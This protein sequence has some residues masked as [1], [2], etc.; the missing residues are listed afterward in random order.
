LDD[1]RRRRASPPIEE[2]NG[3]ERAKFVLSFQIRSA[4]QPFY[5]LSFSL[6]F[7]LWQ[8]R[9]RLH[10]SA[11][12]AGV[13]EHRSCLKTGAQHRVLEGAAAAEEKK[14][15]KKHSLPH[16]LPVHGLAVGQVEAKLEL[17]RDASGRRRLLG[18]LL[19]QEVGREARRR[20]RGAHERG[21]FLEKGPPADFARG[22]S[23]GGGGSVVGERARAAAQEHG[24]SPSQ[25][26]RFFREENGWGGETTS[27][28]KETG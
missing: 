1:G 13:I 18:L 23:R 6:C 20:R 7:P 5:R 26:W 8:E 12:R 2:T 17:V 14:E 16:R 27:E 10:A 21:E 25:H 28:R 4:A 19:G 15:G 11:K 3:I 9:E 22:V 24:R